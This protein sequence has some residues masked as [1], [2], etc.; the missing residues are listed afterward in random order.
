MIGV[1]RVMA[2]AR[3]RRVRIEVELIGSFDAY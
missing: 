1:M 3:R 2:V